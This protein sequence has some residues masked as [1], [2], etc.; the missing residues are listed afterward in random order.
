[1]SVVTLMLLVAAVQGAPA[2]V[3]AEL[4]LQMEQ[5]A[6]SSSVLAVRFRLTN[7]SK[8][9]AYW[10]NKRLPVA[11]VIQDARTAEIEIAVMDARRR[12]VPYLCKVLPRAAT[13]ADFV[14]LRPGEHLERRYQ[15]DSG[16][17]DLAP[18]ERLAIAGSF[19]FVSRD[20][21]LHS[22]GVIPVGKV[23]TTD[24]LTVRVPRRQRPAP[25]E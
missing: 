24:W 3:P 13:T 23:S 20:V 5:V 9:K 1:M 4:S 16:C 7:L 11:H 21:E 25:K 12:S 17:Y 8:S 22:G 6:D 15:F 14:L 10:V 2:Q 18:G 19:E